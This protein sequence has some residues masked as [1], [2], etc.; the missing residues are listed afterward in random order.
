MPPFS[1]KKNRSLAETNNR[2]HVA[3]DMYKYPVAP[4][5]FALNISILKHNKTV[6]RE[7]DRERLRV[8]VVE[9]KGGE[10]KR[11]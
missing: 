11:S 9:R 4:Y 2:T 8:E 7:R 3:S 6:E 1:K 10:E 5:P